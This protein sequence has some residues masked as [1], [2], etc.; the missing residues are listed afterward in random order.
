MAI[1]QWYFIAGNVAMS[2][3]RAGNGFMSASVGKTFLFGAP[4][5]VAGILLGSFI[6]RRLPIETIRKGV[7][8]FI[9]VAGIVAL[10][11]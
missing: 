5:V 9:G 11:V 4:A 2:F 7:Y 8:L 1:A 3:F 10:V 6:F